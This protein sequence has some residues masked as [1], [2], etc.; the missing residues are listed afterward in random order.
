VDIQSPVICLHH[1]HC[2][3]HLWYDDDHVVGLN[4]QRSFV[5]ICLDLNVVARHLCAGVAVVLF[6][7][8]MVIYINAT[9]VDVVGYV[10]HA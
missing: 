9:F 10:H 5:R 3:D 6:S 2:Y 4:I 1:E 8:S 7:I